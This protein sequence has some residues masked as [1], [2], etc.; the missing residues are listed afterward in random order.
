MMQG[1]GY[2]LGIRIENNAL[3]VVTPQDVRD[4]EISIGHLRRTYGKGELRYYNGLW[5]FPLSQE[6]S[7]RFLPAA[8]KAQVRVVWA[9]GAV[10]GKPLYGV[11]IEESIS[12]E[13]L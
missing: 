13:V 1:D 9:N 6:E 2:C 5:L 10:E 3:S 4:V 8:P 11:R 7:F 12:K